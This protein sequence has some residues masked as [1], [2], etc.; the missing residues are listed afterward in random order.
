MGI[1]VHIWSYMVQKWSYMA[2]YVYM[3]PHM[4]IYAHICS[5]TLYYQPFLLLQSTDAASTLTV[6]GPVGLYSK[7]PLHHYSHVH[8]AMYSTIHMSMCTNTY[9]HTH[10]LYFLIVGPY[11][12]QKWR[13][14]AIFSRNLHCRLIY[15]FENA[16]HSPKQMGWGGGGENGIGQVAFEVRSY[17]LACD[18]VFRPTHNGMQT[19]TQ[20]HIL[21]SI[22]IARM[23]NNTLFFPADLPQHADARN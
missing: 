10:I 21:C 22:Y 3:W 2:I 7:K 16:L 4:A 9:T 23:H 19:S 5:V 15:L 11:F 12:C 18:K 14:S 1:Y 20:T 6:S 17:E 13:K 8:R